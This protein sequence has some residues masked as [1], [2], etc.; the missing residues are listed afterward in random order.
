MSVTI[1][2]TLT[3]LNWDRVTFHDFQVVDMRK[4]GFVSTASHLVT[5]FIET[6][7]NQ[8]ITFNMIA[9]CV[10]QS[11]GVPVRPVHLVDIAEVK[12]DVFWRKKITH[13]KNGYS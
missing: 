12:R 3:R 5:T 13:V 11:N 6:T 2:M 7:I 9:S 8:N 10:I 4:L 1:A